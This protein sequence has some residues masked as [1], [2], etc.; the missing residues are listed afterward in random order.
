[1][2]GAVQSNEAS[3]DV[4]AETT[5][6]RTPRSKQLRRIFE[7]EPGYSES[8]NAR[9]IVS[10]A[11]LI[12]SVATL[13]FIV[14][15]K[16]GFYVVPTSSM[17]PTLHPND[18]IVS[19]SASRYTRGQVVVVRDPQKR[20]EYL[21]KRIVGTGNDEVEVLNGRL[22][23]NGQ[24][25]NEPYLGEPMQYQL[26]PTQVGADHVF[27][28]G[29]NRNESEDSHLWKHGVPTRDIMG[30]VRY[31]YSPGARRG[32]RVAYPEVFQGIAHARSSGEIADAGVSGKP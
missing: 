31:I 10:I 5:I 29:D 3:H 9:L 25:V 32:T 7:I 28:L 24:V 6:S 27:L 2:S 19:F 15:G 26:G 13:L 30:A 18:R 23:V 22:M 17:E 4:Y 12:V 20:D 1:M 16:I 8:G 14:S 11:L 21:V